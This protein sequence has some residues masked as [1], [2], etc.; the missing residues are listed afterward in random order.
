MRRNRNT[1]T[2]LTDI[3]D[4][5]DG[6][7]GWQLMVSHLILLMSVSHKFTCWKFNISVLKVGSR[8]TRRYLGLED[9]PHRKGK[10]TPGTELV[11]MMSSCSKARG[12]LFSA[13]PSL[14]FLSLP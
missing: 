14:V 5:L 2:E 10:M 12:C 4:T 7:T 9:G 1:H 6:G 8:P 3:K 13:H 11:T